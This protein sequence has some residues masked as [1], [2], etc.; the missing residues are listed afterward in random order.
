M[1]RP[2]SLRIRTS[3]AAATV[4]S[5]EAW[6]EIT[7]TRPRIGVVLA[8][9]SIDYGVLTDSARELASVT[10]PTRVSRGHF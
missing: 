9:M 8:R 4:A 3:V 6:A 10:Q 1:P 2:T 5:S 7:I